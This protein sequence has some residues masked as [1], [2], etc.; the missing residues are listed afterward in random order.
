MSESGCQNEEVAL[1][2]EERAERKTDPV[3][4]PEDALFR[5]SRVV[6]MPI[7]WI[8]LIMHSCNKY[9]PNARK[10]AFLCC[11]KHTDPGNLDQSC[12]PPRAGE[13]N[14][15]LQEGCADAWSPKVLRAAM[16]H[17]LD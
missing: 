5:A 1:L 3:T 12:V 4:L 16:A 14:I 10:T 17:W 8:A 11:S 9:L 6:K 15:Y 2:A 7:W 13:S